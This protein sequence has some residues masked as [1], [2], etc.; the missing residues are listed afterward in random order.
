[1]AMTWGAASCKAACDARAA[2]LN[3]GFLRILSAADVLL[4]ELTLGATAYGAATT[5]NP[6]IAT[7]NAITR[8]NSANAGGQAAKYQL[9]QSDGTTIEGTGTV[10]AT[11]G[12]GDVELLSITIEA[13][14]PVEISAH[15]IRQS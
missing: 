6:S 13:G 8:D 4:A 11:G 2:R 7:A 3:S 15:T 10:T 5:A 1:M 9:V 12:G 14:L